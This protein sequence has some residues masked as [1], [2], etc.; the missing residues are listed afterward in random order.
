[1]K[2]RHVVRWQQ[3]D[4]VLRLTQLAVCAIHH[5]RMCQRDSALG[6]EIR[7]QEFLTIPLRLLAIRSV[8]CENSM[9]SH[10]RQN[11]KQQNQFPH[12]FQGSPPLWWIRISSPTID[13]CLPYRAAAIPEFDPVQR[14]VSKHLASV[15]APATC[16]IPSPCPASKENNFAPLVFLKLVCRPER[17]LSFRKSLPPFETPE[18]MKTQNLRLQVGRIRRLRKDFPT[19]AEWFKLWTS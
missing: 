4:V 6:L 5:T 18:T 14:Q 8:L 7:N 11:Q 19:R 10:Y 2:I 15:F 1:M 13:E 16:V 17:S 3:H 9:C 12:H